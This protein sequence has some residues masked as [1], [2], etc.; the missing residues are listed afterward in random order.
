M[1]GISAP[2]PEATGCD[3]FPPVPPSNCPVCGIFRPRNRWEV[4]ATGGKWL[5]DGREIWL[6]RPSP[7]LFSTVIGLVWIGLC[8]STR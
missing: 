7:W 4:R 3:D 5:A 2:A 8:R 1:R 6:N